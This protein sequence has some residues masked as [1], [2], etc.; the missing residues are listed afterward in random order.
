[1]KT[2]KHKAPHCAAH[3]EFDQ[4][5]E[6]CQAAFRKY[7]QDM[8]AKGRFKLA[9]TKRV[10]AYPEQIARLLEVLGQPEALVT[11]LSTVYDFLPEKDDAELTQIGERLGVQVRHK[12][13]LWQVAK[14]M[15]LLR[16]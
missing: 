15:A 16:K 2:R 11:D 7:L 1:M 9:S 12:D 14:R 8:L 13:L 3:D 5:C 6:Y 10:D 4:N